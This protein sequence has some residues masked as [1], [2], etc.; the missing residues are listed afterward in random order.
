MS[1]HYLCK[2]NLKGAR[3]DFKKKYKFHLKLLC[4]R[5]IVS[6]DNKEYE[7]RVHPDHL[8]KNFNK[9]VESSSCC[10][11]DAKTKALYELMDED[12]YLF[13][14]HNKLIDK[15]DKE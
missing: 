14:K 13:T 4:S 6:P 2:G 7:I 8:N 1:E 15:M 9:L 5:F 11:Y 3:I 10:S 12:R